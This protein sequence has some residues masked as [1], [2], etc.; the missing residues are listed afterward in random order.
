MSDAD[1]N[2]ESWSIAKEGILKVLGEGV[3]GNFR[4][5]VGTTGI[6]LNLNK[7]NKKKW[8]LSH[9]GVEICTRK[10]DLNQSLNQLRCDEQRKAT[11]RVKVGDKVM[12]QYA[13][14][15]LRTPQRTPLSTLTPFYRVAGKVA[16]GNRG[17]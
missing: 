7:S 11:P 10:E 1:V 15:P 8:V 9:N 12:I 5:P 4:I 16:R 17:W 2:S 13:S 6:E 14:P 3:A